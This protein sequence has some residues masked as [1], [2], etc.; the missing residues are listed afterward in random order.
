MA[1]K[2]FNQ[3][4]IMAD[5][6]AFAAAPIEK[7]AA[8]TAVIEDATANSEFRI[9]NSELKKMG[10]PK[11]T[12]KIDG[13]APVT[14]FFDQE[15][16]SKLMLAKIAHKIEMKDLILGATCMFLEKYYQ[17]G[18]ISLVGQDELEKALDKFYGSY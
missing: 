17:E 11:K 5:V 16:K 13:G 4:E 18:Q 6:A 15:T 14:V 9:Q 10:R 2:R 8:P 3:D 12:R 1:K 7:P